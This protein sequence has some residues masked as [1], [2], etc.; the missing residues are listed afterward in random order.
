MERS[1]HCLGLD[2]PTWTWGRG[3]GC[4]ALSRLFGGFPAP[5][6]L[7]QLFPGARRRRVCS[8]QGAEV[9]PEPASFPF[10]AGPYGNQSHG[11]DPAFLQKTPGMLERGPRSPD[12]S[13][14]LRAARGL[15]PVMGR[16]RTG[17]RCRLSVHLLTIP[18]DGTDGS[19]P[20]GWGEI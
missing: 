7:S 3:E 12:R 11:R 19:D 20:W 9:Q 14:C 10:P 18:R 17:P 13:V 2:W 5:A 16:M 1:S 6:K 15:R 4:V 8:Q